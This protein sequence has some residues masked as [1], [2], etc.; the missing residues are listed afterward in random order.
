[1]SEHVRWQS[2]DA[3]IATINIDFPPIARCTHSSLF[4]SLARSALLSSVSLFA[5]TKKKNN[6]KFFGAA[7]PFIVSQFRISLPRSCLS[8]PEKTNGPI[9][10]ANKITQR[11]QSPLISIPGT[12]IL[13]TREL[14]YKRPS[15]SR[16]DSRSRIDADG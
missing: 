16:D 2:H 5:F 14:N 1:M 7:S 8:A 10:S 13:F 9:C 3:T 6:V 4:F 11:D 15:L 12:P